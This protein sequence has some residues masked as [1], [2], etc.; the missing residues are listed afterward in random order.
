MEGIA[1]S[2]HLIVLGKPGRVGK[3]HHPK[4]KIERVLA[5]GIKVSP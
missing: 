5:Q 4:D 3:S 1:L 2:T